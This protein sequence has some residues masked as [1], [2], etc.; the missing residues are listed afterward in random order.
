MQNGY[1]IYEFWKSKTFETYGLFFSLSDKINLRKSFKYVALSNL[2]IYYT[3]KSTKK[4][5]K[6]NKFKMS[7]LTWN[8]KF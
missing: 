7:T 8:R 6:N 2:S 3:W 1:Y 5:F 4:E